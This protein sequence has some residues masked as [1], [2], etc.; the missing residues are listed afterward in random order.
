MVFSLFFFYHLCDDDWGWPPFLGGSYDVR[1]KYE[2]LFFIIFYIRKGLP[3]YVCWSSFFLFSPPIE[4]SFLF[5]LSSFLFVR[6]LL[7]SLGHPT[8]FFSIQRIFFFFS[9]FFLKKMEFQFI[10]WQYFPIIGA[11]EFKFLLEK[12]KKKNI[13]DLTW[14]C[15]LEI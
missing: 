1:M 8:L 9:F 13:F 11:L 6:L 7:Y 10:N 3:G 12:D 14:N 5:T 2:V 4:I 15:G